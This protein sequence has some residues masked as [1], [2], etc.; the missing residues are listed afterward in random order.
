MAELV[1]D[2][3]PSD[4][5]E[6]GMSTAAR[7]QRA[8]Q[9][10]ESISHDHDQTATQPSVPGSENVTSSSISASAVSAHRG[11]ARRHDVDALLGLAARLLL[12]LLL[13]WW[14]WVWSAGCWACWE[15]TNVLVLQIVQRVL[16][17]LLFQLQLLTAAL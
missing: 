17:F 14:L 12:L 11:L 3:A 10:N 2:V 7:L 13:L 4:G 6:L 1:V 8:T 5:M 9:H 16:E 15:R